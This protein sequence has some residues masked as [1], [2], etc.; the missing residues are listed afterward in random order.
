[1][2]DFWFPLAVEHKAPPMVRNPRKIRSVLVEKNNHSTTLV[3]AYFLSNAC[4]MSRVVCEHPA[5]EFVVWSSFRLIVSAQ[6]K[7]D[8]ADYS[9]GGS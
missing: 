8:G 3:G 9:E 5:C 2:T 6:L 7:E 1:M 4:S